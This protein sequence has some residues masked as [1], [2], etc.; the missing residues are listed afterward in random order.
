MKVKQVPR[1]IRRVRKLNPRLWGPDL[2][3]DSLT[4]W[5]R[6]YSREAFN[7][8]IEKVESSCSV[9]LGRNSGTKLVLSMKSF[10]K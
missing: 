9:T 3:K 2:D 1:A 7:T 5:T 8:I 10:R 6:S 4:E